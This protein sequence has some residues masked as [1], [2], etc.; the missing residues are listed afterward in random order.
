MTIRKCRFMRGITIAALACCMISVLAVVS[1]A[2]ETEEMTV[3]TEPLETETIIQVEPE[4][5]ACEEQEP[6][7]SEEAAPEEE[8]KDQGVEEVNEAYD[9]TVETGGDAVG[10]SAGISYGGWASLGSKL[11]YMKF[12][13]G[14][15]GPD[16]E[17]GVWC[18]CIDI[19]TDTKDGH[20]YS[21]TTL[22][23]AGY[24]EKESGDK[25]RNIL[26]NS[27]P[28]MT[29]EEMI[30]KHGLENLM[31]EEAFMATQWV[32]WYYS[33][34]DGLVDAGGGSYYP[35]ELYKPSEYPRETISM[36]YDDENGTEAYKKS[37]NIVKLAKALDE[38]AP[39]GAYEIE[40]ANIVLEKTVYDDKV[41]FDYGNTT[42]LESLE[43]I[44][45]TVKDGKGR[46]VPFALKGN[47]ITVLAKDISMEEDAAE[48]T[49]TLE[50]EQVLSKDAYFFS[51]EGGRDASQSR[52][53]VYEGKTPVAKSEVFALTKTEFE[54]AREDPNRP[55]DPY[56]PTVPSEPDEPTEQPEAE[57]IITPENPTEAETLEE[58]NVQT[59][60]SS[61][62]CI[63]EPETGDGFDA[64]L[65][66]TLMMLALAGIIAS[67]RL[68]G[69]HA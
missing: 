17:D 25:I 67:I 7:A 46:E 13:E 8:L 19:S 36:W 48:L 69:K 42:G 21:M 51:P 14:T 63:S 49:V 55:E 9:Y 26:L 6:V 45:I 35:A 10:A 54:E 20:K 37:A 53:A 41:V 11:S 29:I 12:P 31:E 30:A 58:M 1:F 34:P 56:D 44:R 22:D 24:Y 62:E 3:E 43:N 68:S 50:A 33:N 57:E 64:I 40:P 59:S 38:L 18:Y 66:M 15:A 65:I 27:Y 28:N 5:V 32:L 39:A 60:G 4:A 61:I 52:V 16:G 23:A 47:K 2:E